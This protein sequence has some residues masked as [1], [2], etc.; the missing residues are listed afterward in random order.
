MFSY[1]FHSFSAEVVC[2]ID[3]LMNFVTGY[4]DETKGEIVLSQRRIAWHYVKFYFWIDLLSSIPVRPLS[5][6]MMV[7]RRKCQLRKHEVNF[8]AIWGFELTL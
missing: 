7:R 2:L 3:I 6:F 4:Y 5:Y 8:K 1:V